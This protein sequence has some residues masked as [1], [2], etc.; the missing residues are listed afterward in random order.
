VHI[1]SLWRET[2]HQE[3][4]AGPTFIEAE[5]WRRMTGGSTCGGAVLRGGRAR[6]A[7]LK[8]AAIDL[9]R[10]HGQAVLARG[11]PFS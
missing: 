3:G 1:V 7:E 10:L 11:R 8:S 5:G 6:R 2:K 4:R 9:V